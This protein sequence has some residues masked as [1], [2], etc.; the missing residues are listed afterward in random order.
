[1]AKG[2]GGIGPPPNI[3]IG[4]HASEPLGQRGCRRPN[5]GK[6]EVHNDI[7]ALKSDRDH[8]TIANGAHRPQPDN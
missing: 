6:K 3:G 1:M 8:Q 4:E 7:H 2:K 5:P